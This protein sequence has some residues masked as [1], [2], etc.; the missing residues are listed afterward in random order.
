MGLLQRARRDTGEALRALQRAL[1][2]NPNYTLA[3]LEEAYTLFEMERWEEARESYDRVLSAGLGS[4]DIYLHIG[5]INFNLGRLEDSETAFLEAL[6]INP[7]EELAQFYLGKVYRARGEREKAQMAWKQFLAMTT[8]PV[9]GAE[10]Q[11]ALEEP[12]E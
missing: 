2:I 9:R 1:N 8:D 7:N 5:Q 4:S 3:R 6:R 12:D 10:A 11:A